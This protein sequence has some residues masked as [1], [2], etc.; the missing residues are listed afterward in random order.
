MSGRLCA[1][2]GTSKQVGLEI[3][4][5]TLCRPCR[6]RRHRKPQPCPVCQEVRPLA[7][8]RDDLIV[9]AGCAGAASAFACQEC[10][11]EEHQYGARRCSRCIL[12][13]RLTILLTDPTTGNI[14]HRL[15]PVFDEM[16]N[17][18]K[19]QTA[20][21]WLG[22]Q[23]C[24][25]GPRLLGQMARGEIEISH[26]TFRALPQDKAHEWL[27][28][29]L[30]SLEVI[31]PWNPLIERM[32]PWLADVLTDVPAAHADIVRQYALW[33]VIRHMRHA[34]QR[35]TLTQSVAQGARRR[36]RATIEFLAILEDHGQTAATATQDH[37]DHFITEHPTQADVL[38][39]FVRWLRATSVNTGLVV[40][41]TQHAAPSVTVSDEQRWADVNRLLHDDGLRSY[42]RL[43]G[44]FTILF[45]QPMNRIVRMR[46]D[47]V[48]ITD[49]A[50]HVTFAAA[51]IEMP[52]IVD[53]L[54]RT[55]LS[56]RGKS[57][58]ASRDNGWL[59]PGGIP[60]RH[61][62]TENVRAGLV[63]IGIKPYES[64]KAAMFQ[65]AGSMPSPVL[66]ELLGTTDTHAA[67]WAHLAARD[68]NDYVGRRA[69]AGAA[70]A[71]E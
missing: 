18:E 30:S 11:S 66:A 37:L 59:F 52:E 3:P 2:C 60:G 45:A 19:P 69:D 50:V 15:R 8:P 34:A 4:E 24:S 35:G 46:T 23:K 44:L 58:Y 38:S 40:P 64:R 36:I 22:K 16:V 67:N 49:D 62:A 53:D 31:G 71:P 56:Q 13:E 26:D 39:G 42:T 70:T 43:G 47:Q 32:E 61:L 1:D 10:G 14:H 7:Y 5:R 41:W 6:T 55:H 27:R 21:W 51:P 20:V 63:A 9:C 17:S 12:R 25:T 29:L 33:N 28:N 48:T 65:L 54:I 68:W 57:L